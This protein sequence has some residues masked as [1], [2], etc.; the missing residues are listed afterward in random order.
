MSATYQQLLR[1]P[2][3]QKKRLE[4]LE[5]DHWK[6]VDCEDEKTTLHVDHAYYEYGKMPWEYPDHTLATLCAP[7]H[8]RVTALRKM[9]SAGMRFLDES[10]LWT[11]LGVID[12][13]TPCSGFRLYNHEHAVGVAAILETTPSDV[14]GRTNDGWFRAIPDVAS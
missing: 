13:L 9:I 5:R 4:I 2:R 6:C 14:I 7:C 1:D 10:D 12:A 3:W 11:V 8:E